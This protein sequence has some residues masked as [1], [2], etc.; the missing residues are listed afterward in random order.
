MHGRDGTSGV[1]WRKRPRSVTRCCC[2]RFGF[3]CAALL[4]LALRAL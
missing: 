2:R 4:L 3:G 1:D